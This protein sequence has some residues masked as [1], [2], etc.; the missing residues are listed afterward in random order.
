MPGAQPAHARSSPAPARGRIGSPSSG[1]RSRRPAH[2]S[3]SRR[4]PAAA[5]RARCA[6]AGEH[7]SRTRSGAPLPRRPPHARPRRQRPARADSADC[8]RPRRLPAVETCA[9]ADL[10]ETLAWPGT[11][12]LVA[13]HWRAGARELLHAASKR[14]PTFALRAGSCPSCARP[15]S[16]PALPEFA[17]RRSRPTARSSTISSSHAS[18]RRCSS[19]TRRPLR[20]H[21]RCRSPGSSPTRQRPCSA[22]QRIADNPGRVGDRDS[23]R[24]QF[25]ARAA[26]ASPSPA[27]TSP[28][29]GTPVLFLHGLAGYAGEWRTTAEWLAGDHRVVALDG[30]G[31]GRSERRPDDVSIEAHAA[32]AA[33][34]VEQL[35]LDR[36]IVVGQ[37]LGGLTAIALA[38]ARPGARQGGRGRRRRPGRRR[39]SHRRRSRSVAA[40]LARAVRVGARGR[41][42]LRRLARKRRRVGQRAGTSRGWLVAALRL[43]RDETNPGRGA[44][45]LVLGASGSG[46]TRPC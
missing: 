46:S 43:R 35:E 34:A 45:A 22:E 28:V 7:L 21:R 36:V 15:T 10:R 11:R 33:Y 4:L 23:I 24:A 31:H 29:D 38:A 19:A 42:V 18:A 26:T 39:G 12:R 9:G 5:P 25:R 32:D 16:S 13:R 14:A 2:R 1:R 40:P 17:P 44:S 8:R 27:S 37:S 6:R 41:A 30:R 3:V 20:R